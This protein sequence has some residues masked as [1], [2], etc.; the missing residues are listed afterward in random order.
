MNGLRNWQKENWRCQ[1]AGD[2]GIRK[3]ASVFGRKYRTVRPQAAGVQNGE[4]MTR[5]IRIFLGV[6]ILA[7]SISLL[8]WGFRPAR[9]ETRIQNI[10]PAEMQLPTPSSFHIDMPV[11]L[12]ASLPQPWL[13]L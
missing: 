12:H 9:R 5:K 7:I 4:N 2:S 10:S 1:K 13:A 8:I 11:P 3:L 6:L